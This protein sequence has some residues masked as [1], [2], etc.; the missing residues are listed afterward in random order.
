M[1]EREREKKKKRDGK[2]RDDVMER[3]GE[4]TWDKVTK[5]EKE[6]GSGREKK[7]K[8]GRK[9]DKRGLEES[10]KRLGV[11]ILYSEKKISALN[12]PWNCL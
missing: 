7:R 5:I 1:G 3:E 9:R 2:K 6:R 4:R 11:I 10:R 8:E 12:W